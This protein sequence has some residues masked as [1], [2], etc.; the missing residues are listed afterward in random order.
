M[1][2]RSSKGSTCGE[3]PER[4]SR[5]SFLMGVSHRRGN[6]SSHDRCRDHYTMTISNKNSPSSWGIG[7]SG[8]RLDF[9]QKVF[10]VAKI[11]RVHGNEGFDG[12]NRSGSIPAVE[13]GLCQGIQLGHR[14]G[15]VPRLA[16][17]LRQVA[18]YDHLLRVFSDQLVKQRN[19][20]SAPGGALEITDQAVHLRRHLRRLVQPDVQ[21]DQVL[22]HRK[23]V[24][25]EGANLLKNAQ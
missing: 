17:L 1:A 15:D 21:V 11:R 13:Q 12:L 3:S 10:I 22:A 23:V 8:L 4:G 18:P 14:F 9:S 5:G 20:F 7:G 25:L 19:G 24:R 16:I 6:S 2:T